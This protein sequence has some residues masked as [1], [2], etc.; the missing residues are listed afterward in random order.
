M[1]IN[2]SASGG[3]EFTPAPEGFWP[4]VCVDVVDLGEVKSVWEGKEK[5]QHKVR[6][7]WEI[8]QLMDDGRR[9]IVSRRYTASLHEKAQLRK[10][11]DSWRGRQFTPEELREFDLERVLGAPCCVF[12]EHQDGQDGKVWANV[13]KVVKVPAGQERIVA[14]GEYTRVKDRTGQV[15]PKPR[16]APPPFPPPANPAPA[17]ATAGGPPPAPQA[18]IPPAPAPA[19]PTP[20][21]PADDIPF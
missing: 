13:T 5:I 11:L 3:Q 17:P 19:D 2:V 16:S 1:A 12:V 15:A 10:D 20:P 7:A 4:A 14:S 9:Y 18:P 8:N 21:A 6:I